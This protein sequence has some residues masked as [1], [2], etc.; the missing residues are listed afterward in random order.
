M[1]YRTVD[2]DILDDILWNYYQRTD[3]LS[4]VMDFNPGLCEQPVKLPAG[5]FVY[6]PYIAPPDTSADTV[7]D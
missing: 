5:L 7:M 6:L 3:V 4:V 1:I 2:G